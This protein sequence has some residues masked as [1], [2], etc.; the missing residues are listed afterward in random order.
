MAPRGLTLR[1]AR[2]LRTTMT[3]P[4]L[5]MWQALRSRRAGG[6]GFRRQ[7]PVG[8][9]IVDFYCAEHCL[10][11][12]VDGWGHNLGELGRDDR[13]DADLA[14]RGVKVVRFTA[15]EVLGNLDGVLRTILHECNLS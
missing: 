8:P 10:A 12:E 4:E 13:R 11:V 2:T 7:H 9:W 3:P 6:L 1:R 14:R 5:A 15:I